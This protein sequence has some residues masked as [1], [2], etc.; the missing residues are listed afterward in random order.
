MKHTI[1]AAVL[2][3]GAYANGIPILEKRCFVCHGART[4]MAN[5]RLDSREALLRVVKPGASAESKL[6]AMIEGRG[7]TVM[8]PSGP[9]LTG[10]EITTIRD[11]IDGGAPWIAA[12]EASGQAR[13]W[14]FQPIS[15]PT[16]PAVRTPAWVRNQ[17]DSFVL[18]RLERE[19]IAPSP[20]ASKRT[21]I[22]RAS[23]DLTGLPPSPAQV[24]AFLSDNRPDAYERLVDSLLESEHFGE[25]WARQWLD[26]ARYADSDGYEKDNVRAHA[27][28]YRNW[29]IDALNSDMPFDRFTIE[30]M[31]GD[32]LPGATA[33]QKAATGFHRNTLTNREGGVKIEQFRT[34]AVKDRAA[35]VGTVWLGLTVGCAQCHDHKYDP[36]TQREFYQLYAFFDNADEVNVDAPMPG[37]M[38]PYLAAL[39][40]YRAKRGELL[41]KY[42]VPEMQPAWEAQMKEARANPGKWTDWDHA[43]DAFQKYL[44]NSDAIVDIPAAQR[45]E[46][47][48][49]A[50]TDHFVINYHRVISKELWKQLAFTDL[51]KQLNELAAAFPALT[52]AQTIAERPAG[53]RRKTFLQVRGDYRRSGAEVAEGVPGFLP[54]LP[55]GERNRLALG[56]WLVSRENPLVARVTVNRIWQEYFGRG[57]VRTPEDFG[58][59]GERPT[60]P[61]LLDFLASR[62]IDSG[63]KVKDL[64]RLI[65]TSAAYRQSSQARA[66]SDLRDPDNRLLARQARLRLPAE[67]VRDSALA[68]SELLYPLVGGKSMRPPQPKGV[69]ELGY[70][71][72]VKWETSPGR[73]RYR[74]GLYIHFQRTVPYPQLMLF[75]AP[76]AN[77][78]ACR[79][80][81]SNTPLQAL[82]L[83]ND[84]VFVEA[85]RAFSVRIL[86]ETP[87]AGFDARI[88]HAFEICL[89]RPPTLSERETLGAYHRTQWTIFEK[90]PAAAQEWSPLEVPGVARVE[91]ST[92][93]GIASVLLNLDEFI[94]RE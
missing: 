90:D 30:Q 86:R 40:G 59:Q 92:W 58:T 18:A 54:P 60:H 5:L 23:L 70:G 3:G 47:Q 61:E 87:G 7:K 79:R 94:T 6:V 37:E 29:V 33:E 57:L 16:A 63:W 22:R 19:N 73:E 84:P 66:E 20:E 15:R 62:F 39:P 91:S 48:A 89:Q 93:T 41:A 76:D 26:L 51:R 65:V 71:T 24:A 52:E 25:R 36:I 53:S 12:A 21:L 83:L 8:P 1:L 68:V 42:R 35:T 80:D 11:W 31:A 43:Y 69:A 2:A 74:R 67:L 85:A 13:H 10:A 34:E 45:T 77:M 46:K 14:S 9:R 32:L 72:S 17:V 27:W 44:D 64:H 78:S 4:Q 88:R 75:D 82:N 28:R 50:M 49:D 55:N 38:G 56:R 81:R